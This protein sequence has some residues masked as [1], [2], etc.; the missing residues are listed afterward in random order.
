VAPAGDRSTSSAQNEEHRTDHQ[1]D[2]P[3]RLQNRYQEH[4]SENEQDNSKE[5][6][7]DPTPIRSSMS[8]AG[9]EL[10]CGK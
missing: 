3:E 6:H 4:E 9:I 1:Q 7:E 2:D 8:T 10:G 5:N